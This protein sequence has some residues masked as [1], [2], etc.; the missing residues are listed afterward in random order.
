M[1]GNEAELRERLRDH[2]EA[3]VRAHEVLLE[4]VA[5]TTVPAIRVVDEARRLELLDRGKH[6]LLRDLEL[7]VAA[8]LRDQHDER[9]L[10]QLVLEVLGEVETPQKA[11]FL[12]DYIWARDRIP[13]NTR[14]FG[15]LR[16]DERRSWTQ[17]PGKRRAY[18]VPALGPA[19]NVNRRWMSR[20]D[21][22][23][24]RRA[25]PSMDHEHLLEAESVRSLIKARDHSRGDTRSSFERALAEHAM[26]LQL[27][28]PL[29][30][31]FEPF[32]EKLTD[33]D[34]ALDVEE[35]ESRAGF[36]RL[37][38]REIDELHAKLDPDVRK[39][40]AEISKLPLEEQLWGRSS[41]E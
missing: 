40:V 11:G 14:S 37:L 7:E 32:E 16:R 23:L 25:I 41:G 6:A 13:V 12:R 22:P 4:I 27:A 5:D 9:S 15:A 39:V 8:S 34:L 29:D 31:L 20:S 28:I 24:E 2:L 33:Y 19:G 36:A 26:T 1:E 3:S 30:E 10:R 17:N 18:V 38:G 21:W 35:V